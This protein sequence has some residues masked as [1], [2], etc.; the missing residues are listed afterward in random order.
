MRDQKLLQIF[1]VI[2]NLAVA[3]FGLAGFL[4]GRPID[5]ILMCSSGGVNCVNALKKPGRINPRLDNIARGL[6][7]AGNLYLT[8]IGAGAFFL[9][10][11]F[12][13]FWIGTCL[14][15]A[16]ILGFHFCRKQEDV[17]P[18]IRKDST[19]IEKVLPSKPQSIYQNITDQK[20]RVELTIDTTTPQRKTYTVGREGRISGF[21]FLLFLGVC[22]YT[23]NI[24]GFFPSSSWRSQ[25][26]LLA[27]ILAVAVFPPVYRALKRQN[28][29]ARKSDGKRYL[30]FNVV[31]IPIFFIIWSMFQACLVI[32]LGHAIPKLTGDRHQ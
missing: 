30:P 17:S 13:H 9:D 1:A 11:D 21:L 2:L 3:L 26:D 12:H 25:G 32:G 23:I 28:F 14:T 22:F 20:P 10:R 18:L 4:L 15:L 29:G 24:S 16:A 7:I 8:F 19:R 27:V 31:M 6:G 5:A